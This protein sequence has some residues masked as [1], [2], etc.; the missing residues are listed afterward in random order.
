ML[1]LVAAPLP[2][3]APLLHLPTPATLQG[4]LVLHVLPHLV[5][6]PAVEA[7]AEEALAVRTELVQAVAVLQPLAPQVRHSR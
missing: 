6:Q 5:R 2:L 1:N 3:P 7:E 4:V